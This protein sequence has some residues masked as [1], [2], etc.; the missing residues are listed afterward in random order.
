MKEGVADDAAADGRG[1]P[2]D[3]DAQEIEVFSG[4]P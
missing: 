4:S 1:E 2:E 3:E